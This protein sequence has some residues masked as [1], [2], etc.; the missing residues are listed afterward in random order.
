MNQPVTLSF[1]F[2]APDE[3]AAFLISISSLGAATPAADSAAAK[4]ETK[5]AAKPPKP[6]KTETPAASPPPAAETPKADTAASEKKADAPASAKAAD[7][8]EKTGFAEKIAGYL[9]VKESEGYADRRAKL[10][11]LLTSFDVKKGPDLKPEQFAD[12]GAKLEALVAPA[13]EEELG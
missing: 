4:P 8:Y 11:A 1:T 13:A 7:T 6:A 9:G 12:F 2:P 10:V 3:A 5:G